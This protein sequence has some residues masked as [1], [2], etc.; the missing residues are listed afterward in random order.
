MYAAAFILTAALLT[1][2][3]VMTARIP[4]DR[5]RENM[6]ISAEYLC[7]GS[8]FGNVLE[9]V[10]ASK[11]DRYADSILLAIAW[12]MDPEHPLES[13][14]R[15]GYYYRPD[16]NENEN[17]LEAVTQ[18]RPANRQYL[19]YWHGSIA[20]TAPLLCLIPLA[21]I[22][23]LNGVLLTVLAAWLVILLVR[24]KAYVPAYGVI[25]GLI[26]GGAVWVPLSLEYTWVI[27]LAVM[28]S[29]AVCLRAEKTS[30]E[31]KT[32]LFLV[33]GMLT[34]Y[35]D[36]LT[37]ET[38]TL[39][40]PLLLYIWIRRSNEQKTGKELWRT[41]WTSALAWGIGYAGMWIFKWLLAALVMHEN[42]LPYVS[43][44]ITERL[45]GSTAR[46]GAAGRIFGAL[47]RNIGCLF[48]VGYGPVGAI[49][50]W[51]LAFAAVYYGYVYRKPGYDKSLIRIYMIAGLIPYVRFM[52]LSN[53]SYMHY[54]FTFRAQMA[55][56]LAVVLILE[57]L[58]G[59]RRR[60]RV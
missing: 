27:L 49:A 53:H 19:R 34:S 33:G 38:V 11:V 23:K 5:I 41:A 48:P 56:F 47:T 3:M 37:A 7:S 18:G 10:D 1:S 55:T 39:L 42:V 40:M 4:R 36:F 13:V 31:R 52:V 51:I 30:P 60:R 50:G 21:E 16:Q 8:L 35:M 54:F 20:V 14:A 9:G 17:L 22:Y 12:Q 44:H 15:S 32:M 26:A 28:L 24:R 2:L 43:G 6:R 29:I 46:I 59:R 58:T 25:G 57:E 45:Y